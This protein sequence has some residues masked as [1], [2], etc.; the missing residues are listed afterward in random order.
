MIVSSTEVQNN[1]GKYYSASPWSHMRVIY[2]LMWIIGSELIPGPAMAW[3]VEATGEHLLYKLGKVGQTVF[4]TP[5]PRR[6]QNRH[7]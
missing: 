5:V 2:E 1:F 7:G 6:T 4:L 3:F